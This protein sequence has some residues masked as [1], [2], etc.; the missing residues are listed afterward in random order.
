MTAPQALS[1][2]ANLLPLLS[3]RTVTPRDRQWAGGG[4]GPHALGPAGRTRPRGAGPATV[5]MAT[6]S[7]VLRR[8]GPGPRRGA[9]SPHTARQPAQGGEGGQA[10]NRDNR[11]CG[12][13]PVA[14][15][16]GSHEAPCDRGRTRRPA[17][18][19]P[20]H[21]RTRPQARPLLQQG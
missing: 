15:E 21:Q 14:R 9:W 3:T 1:T 2:G 8:R 17:G 10:P 20:P 12:R 16:T 19:R 6:A 13:G 7:H 18:A 4:H 11:E 5:R